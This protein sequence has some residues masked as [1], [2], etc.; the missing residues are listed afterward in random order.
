MESGANVVEP[1][2]NGNTMLHHLA[3]A[4]GEVGKDSLEKGLELG[5]KINAGGI[6]V[7]QEAGADMFIIND[8]GESLLHLLRRAPIGVRIPYPWG[9]CCMT[10]KQSIELFKYLLEFGLEHFLEDHRQ[11]TPMEMLTRSDD[12]SAYRAA[13]PKTAN[14][15]TTENSLVLGLQLECEDL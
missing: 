5:R 13:I 1:D 7:F 4:M 9:L 15:V 11:R 12:N 2:P 14:L 3:A 8:A 10:Q 6:Q